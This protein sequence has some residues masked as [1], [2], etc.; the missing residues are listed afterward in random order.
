VASQVPVH[1]NLVL[2]SNTFTDLRDPGLFITRPN[3]VVV[4][5]N[6]FTNT[7]L[8]CLPF[9]DLNLGNANLGG[10]IVVDHAHSIFLS[11]TQCRLR[12][13]ALSQSTQNQAME[14]NADR[15]RS[16]HH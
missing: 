6:Q 3:D 14:P 13:P 4:V 16:Q 7:N 10:S 8:S 5:S 15:V 2:H 12:P 9:L 1:A 11:A